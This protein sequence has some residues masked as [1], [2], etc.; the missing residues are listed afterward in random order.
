MRL[1]IIALITLPQILFANGI[2]YKA[3][4][5]SSHE[6]IVKRVVFVSQNGAIPLTVVVSPVGFLKFSEVWMGDRNFDS[7]GYLNNIKFGWQHKDVWHKTSKLF[8]YD[9]LTVDTIYSVFGTVMCKTGDVQWSYPDESI[10]KPDSSRNIANEFM[11]SF[12]FGQQELKVE[13]PVVLRVTYPLSRNPFESNLSSIT[14]ELT[15]SNILLKSMVYDIA[16]IYNT[17]VEDKGT[18]ILNR[19]HYRSFNKVLSKSSFDQCV[20]CFHAKD[21]WITGYDF[22]LEYFHKGEHYT[23]F[24]SD[25]AKYTSVREERPVVRNLVNLYMAAKYFNGFYFGVP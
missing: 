23:Y 16:D 7:I 3:N 2:D 20:T 13:S 9:T 6:N 5:T 21:S 15:D 8:R 24:L 17:V 10:N 11:Y 25:F 14:I 18:A 12:L 1:F 19:R 22:V 4:D